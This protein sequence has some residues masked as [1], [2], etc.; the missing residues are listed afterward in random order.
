MSALVER[1]ID[2]AEFR[3]RYSD[4][5]LG[6]DTMWSDAEFG[7][8][9]KLFAETDDFEPDPLLRAELV[10]SLDADELRQSAANALGRLR[11]LAQDQQ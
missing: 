7:V 5:Y 11:A 2:P 8:L 10:H 9:D 4:L 6:D 3:Q 1:G